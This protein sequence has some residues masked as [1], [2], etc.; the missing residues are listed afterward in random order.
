MSEKVPIQALGSEDDKRKLEEICRKNERSISGQIRFWI[1]QEHE[2]L[3][4]RTAS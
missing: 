3:Q 1:N 2:R 4:L